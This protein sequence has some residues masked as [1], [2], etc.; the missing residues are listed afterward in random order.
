M[1]PIGYLYMFK[2]R[3]GENLKH[4]INENKKMIEEIV[5]GQP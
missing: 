2:N 3:I 1:I 5:R 4:K